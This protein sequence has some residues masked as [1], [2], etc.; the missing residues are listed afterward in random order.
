M[1]KHMT[2]LNSL[3]LRSN[4]LRTREKGHS[5]LNSQH[6]LSDHD[7]QRARHRWPQPRPKG[8]TAS[9]F[10]ITPPRLPQRGRIHPGPSK[11]DHLAGIPGTTEARGF[12]RGPEGVSFSALGP[13]F[14][15]ASLL[16]AARNCQSV[17]TALC[18]PRA[19]TTAWTWERLRPRMMARMGNG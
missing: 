9:F 8:V 6:V 7:R 16:A 14:F 15:F 12:F 1:L 5:A 4:T 17:S 2:T 19:R 10:P 13:R 18:T 3:H 11:F